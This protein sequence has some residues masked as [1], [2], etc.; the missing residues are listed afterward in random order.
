MK[1]L[2]FDVGSKH[3]AVCGLTVD[4]SGKF[5]VDH[6]TVHNCMPADLNVNKASVEHLAPIF[7]EHCRKY[8]NT[9]VSG[10]DRIFIENQP[11]GGRGAARNLKTKVLSHLLQCIL[12]EAKN[13]APINFVHPGLKLKDMP[14]ID[15]KSTYR[16]NKKYAV[17][18]T[19]EI[20]ASADCT[21]KD[22]AQGLMDSAGKKK[23]D[24]ADAFLQ[25]LIAGLMYA[26]GQIVEAPVPTKI[27]RK[28]SAASK[29]AKAAIEAAAPEPKPK[30]ARKAAKPEPVADAAKPESVAE[31]AKPEPVA[32]AVKPEPVAEDAAKPEPAPADAKPSKKRKTK[33][34]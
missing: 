12:L 26:R 21:N 30:K 13:G 17:E 16:A 11:M 25:G 19:N 15:G 14:R 33:T 32:E 18:K 27:S 3:L 31:A 22:V 9:W 34:T 7:Y 23:D 5:Q 10:V 6:W 2:S 20:I 28:R 24:L 29:T 1:I 4:T 8:A